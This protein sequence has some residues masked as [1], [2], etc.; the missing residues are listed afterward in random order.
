MI[1]IS[2][3]TLLIAEPF[4]KDPN[5]QRSVVLI[6]EHENS[7]GSFGITIN[8]LTKDVLGDY[9][10]DFENFK[11]PVFDGGPVGK[12]NMHFLHRRPDLIDGG[13]EIAN[14]IFWGGDYTTAV[15][16]VIENTISA[17]EIRFY[18]GY[19]GWEKNQL[20]DEMKEKSWLLVDAKPAIVFHKN[21]S[22]IWKESV[23]QMGK[24]FHPV[25]HYPLDP[26]YN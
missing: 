11:M 12:D 21:P 9:L 2:C 14:G 10:P 25:I 3:G 6:C 20:K 7:S 1:D 4:M 18:L 23:K 26:S 15:R 24:E 16:L 8:R 19:A 5:F 13:K 22:Q 17:N